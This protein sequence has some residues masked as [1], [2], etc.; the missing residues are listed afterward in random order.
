ML[1]D[2]V[3]NPRVSKDDEAAAGRNDED[4]HAVVL[5]GTMHPESVE[6][7]LGRLVDVAPEKST[8][9]RRG[10]PRTFDARRV[11]WLPSHE[12]HRPSSEPAAAHESRDF[13]HD[14]DAPP[15]PDR[16]PPPPKPRLRRTHSPPEAAS[17]P[18]HRTRSS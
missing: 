17:T 2:L 18:G 12:R 5:A 13:H 8:K 11:G 10:F 9:L 15:P 1:A 6:A 3:V 16:P 14:P 7:R 4:E